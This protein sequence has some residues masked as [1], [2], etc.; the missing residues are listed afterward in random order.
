MYKTNIVFIIIDTLRK[1]YAKNLEQKLSKYG[2]VIYDNAIAPSPW[3]TPSHAS[4]FTGLYPA[5]H[6]AHETKTIKD[7]DVK[8]SAKHKHRLLSCIMRSLGYRTYLL[9]ANIHVTPYFGF[10]GFQSF[11]DTHKGERVEF[12]NLNDLL[13]LREIRLKFKSKYERFMAMLKYGYI[14]LLFKYILE[15]Y[16]PRI[17]RPHNKLWPLDKGARKTLKIFSKHIPW[18]ER[19]PKFVFVNLMEVHEPYLLNENPEEISRINYR[20]GKLNYNVVNAWKKQYLKEVKYITKIVLELMDILEAR[21]MLEDSLVIITSDHGQLL[22]EHGRIRHGTFLY[23]ELLRVP[24]LIRYPDNERFI[25]LEK[26][27]IELCSA[28]TSLK[29]ISLTNLYYFI[30]NIIQGKIDAATLKLFTDTVFAESYGIE[31]PYDPPTNPIEKANIDSLE[32][33]RIAIYHK[34]YK[35]VFNVDDGI[36]EDIISYERANKQAIDI[37]DKDVLNKILDKL[38]TFMKVASLVKSI[39]KV[40]YKSVFQ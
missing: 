29:Y 1:D 38:N 25:K 5:Y 40:T 6:G 10:H 32:K 14:D 35:V 26:A 30:I 28:D 34:E 12:L 8:L 3:T 36:I 13:K 2:F 24:M 20:T 37:I 16:V 7:Y 23:D 31:I 11:Y 17:F 39:K 27:S 18:N 21:K 9:S 33:H 15:K 22:G 4:I 19:K